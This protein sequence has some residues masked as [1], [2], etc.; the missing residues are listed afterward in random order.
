M[1][2]PE[3]TLGPTLPSLCVGLLC[4]I[5]HAN[6]LSSVKHRLKHKV[7]KL[8]AGFVREKMVSVNP[9]LGSIQ[10]WTVHWSNGRP[11][12]A[13]NFADHFARNVTP[14]AFAR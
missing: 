6:A 5:K 10:H 12:A 7:F 14:L 4:R 1:C 11:D 2:Y 9:A 3:S 8:I 13:S